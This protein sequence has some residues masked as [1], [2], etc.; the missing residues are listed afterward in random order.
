MLLLLL[1]LLRS[2]EF[3]AILSQNIFDSIGRGDDKFW[4]AV[5][6]VVTN[7]YRLGQRRKRKP[8]VHARKFP[9]WYSAIHVRGKKIIHLVVSRPI[10]Q[11][12]AIRPRIVVEL[13]GAVV[14]CLP[15]IS[16]RSAARSERASEKNARR[17]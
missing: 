13:F 2:A 3:A 1:K 8:P 15:L 5:V 10:S 9:F 11:C 4:R 16:A 14:R 17:C 12:H 7:A 6:V